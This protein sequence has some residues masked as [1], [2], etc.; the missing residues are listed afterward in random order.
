[1]DTAGTQRAA[2]GARLRSLRR[3]KGV[4][5]NAIAAYLADEGRS[6]T[7]QAVSYWERGQATPDARTV[8]LLE[9]FFDLADGQLRVLLGYAPGATVDERLTNLERELAGVKTLA[10]RVLALVE[11][12]APPPPLPTTP[13]RKAARP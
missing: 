9:R 4:S 7:H 2:F 11:Q 6:I 3:A 10:E 12:L 1:M 8:T 13:P 5:Q